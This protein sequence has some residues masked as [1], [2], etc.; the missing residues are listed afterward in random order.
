MTLIDVNQVL[1]RAL[2][3][4]AYQLRL[5][6]VD[7]VMRLAPDLPK[8]L[9]DFHLL[10]QTFLNIIVNAH[11]ALGGVERRGRLTLSTR[12]EGERIIVELEDNGPGIPAGLRER[13]FDPFFTT[14]DVGS[15][16]GLGLSICYGV[17]QEH[18]GR[19]SVE[20]EA[21][22]GARFVVELPVTRRDAE[23]QEGAA[24]TEAQI[25]APAPAGE[26]LRVLIVDDEATVVEVLYQALSEEGYQI[27]TASNGSAAL[28]RILKNRFDLI[29]SDLKMPGMHGAELYARVREADPRMAEAILFTTGDTASPETQLFL[30]RCGNPCLAKPFL[31]EEVRE[32]V[33]SHLLK[34]R[35]APAVPA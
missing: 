21:G 2:E 31:L 15:G 16:T 27:E 33:Q 32:A 29:I 12:L 34:L 7:V 28:G 9:A 25:P 18:G 22:S 26:A 13:I 10:Q 8:T 3:L 19:I 6:N 23:R 35:G 20:G 1:E 24:P 4:R 17:V 5:D 30:R 14:K 11:Q